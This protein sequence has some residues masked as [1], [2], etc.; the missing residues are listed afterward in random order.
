MKNRKTKL[1][2]P[3]DLFQSRR[4]SSFVP[5]NEATKKIVH[6]FYHLNYDPTQ[7][8]VKEDDDDK[9]IMS[10]ITNSPKK[11]MPPLPKKDDDL[12]K[13]EVIMLRLKT[14]VRKLRNLQNKMKK[15]RLVC[16]AN[17]ALTK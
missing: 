9:S 1:I 12:Y 11:T 6:N 16:I 13:Q 10:V 17:I 4:T 3:A 5:D 7:E 2:I 8:I 15:R 14:I